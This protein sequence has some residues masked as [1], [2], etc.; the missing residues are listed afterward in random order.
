MRALRGGA[1]LS[2]YWFILVGA[3]EREPL[4]RLYVYAGMCR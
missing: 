2:G 4:A 1:E 3:Y